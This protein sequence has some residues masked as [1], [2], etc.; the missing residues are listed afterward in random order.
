MLY[1]VAGHRGLANICPMKCKR[2]IKRGVSAPLRRWRAR[3]RAQANPT[4]YGR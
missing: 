3:W 4:V 2:P 1:V